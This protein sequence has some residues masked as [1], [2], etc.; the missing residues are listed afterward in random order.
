MNRVLHHRFPY[1]LA[2]ALLSIVL[3]GTG[4]AGATTAGP[5]LKGTAA[6]AGLP[7]SIAVT[8]DGFTPGGR[9][10]VALYDLWGAKLLGTRWTAASPTVYG[11][12][13]SID[14]AAGFA[15]GGAL[16]V[17]FAGLCGATPMV[18]A[19]DEATETWSNLLDVD[20]TAVEIAHFGA[21]GSVD[22]ARG[23]LPG[24]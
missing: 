11:R 7:G 8:G 2:L 6:V 15:A 9:I 16:A 23:Y 24:C 1:V 13:G 4:G 12:D 22:P 21:G 3:I 5:T 10:Y 14:P 18:R 19:Y 17:R 20:P